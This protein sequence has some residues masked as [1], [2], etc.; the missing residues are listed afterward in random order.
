MEPRSEEF[1]SIEVSTVQLLLML[2]QRQQ[3]FRLRECKPSMFVIP[4]MMTGR[5][6]SHTIITF[7]QAALMVTSFLGVTIS[8][9]AEELSNCWWCD[10][11]CP[12]TDDFISLCPKKLINVLIHREI[13]QKNTHLLLLHCL[14]FYPTFRPFF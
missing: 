10:A 11:A 8:S 2:V 13:T 3:R 6:S 9:T 5:R 14:H 1:R 4:V 12:A 7:H